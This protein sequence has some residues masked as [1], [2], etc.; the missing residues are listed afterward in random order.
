MILFKKKHFKHFILYAFVFF[1]YLNVWSQYKYNEITNINAINIDSKSGLPTNYVT[2]VFK[3]SYGFYWLGTQAGLCKYDGYKI[4]SFKNNNKDSFS[5]KCS[6]IFSVNQY[7]NYIIVACEDGLTFYDYYK[8]KF[9]K[10]QNIE[11]KLKNTTVF[12]IFN[13]NHKLYI[14]S[15]NGFYEFNFKDS[16]LIKYQIKSDKDTNSSF[17][18]TTESKLLYNSHHFLISDVNLGIKKIDTLSHTIYDKLEYHNDLPRDM[19]QYGNAIYI[20]Y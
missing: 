5:L 14:V 17:N 15:S 3:D 11:K 6:N 13:L 19:I 16:V 8:D 7:K 4:Y 9:F 12:N 1:V 2:C 18:F 20:V 10:I